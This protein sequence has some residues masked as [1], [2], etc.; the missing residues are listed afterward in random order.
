MSHPPVVIGVGPIGLAVAAS[1]ADR[2]MDFLVLEAGPETEVLI[3][4][5]VGAR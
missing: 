5:G 1:A 2:A 4:G 3:V